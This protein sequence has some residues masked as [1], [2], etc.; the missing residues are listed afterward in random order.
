[1]GGFIDEIAA[2]LD[3]GITCQAE[4]WA[5][6]GQATRWVHGLVEESW[7]D[8]WSELGAAEALSLVP[9]Q[10]RPDVRL[11]LDEVLGDLHSFTIEMLLAAAG[12][13][14]LDARRRVDAVL[15]PMIWGGKLRALGQAAEHLGLPT[16]VIQDGLLAPYGPSNLP[17]VRADH[18]LV[19]GPSG[20]KWFTE[21]GMDRERLLVAGRCMWGAAFSTACASRA[22]SAS[23]RTPTVLYLAPRPAS[24]GA[25]HSLHEAE[26][27]IEAVCSAVSMIPAC[28]LVV[29]LHPRTKEHP[30][31]AWVRRVRRRLRV[32]LGLKGVHFDSASS[33]E[34]C[35]VSA[36]VVVCYSSTIPIQMA[37]LGKR[38]VIVDLS[39]GD[40]GSWKGWSLA[41]TP[42]A[43]GPAVSDALACRDPSDQQPL[44]AN[45]AE[46]V[47]DGVGLDGVAAYINGI[48]A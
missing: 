31:S 15:L 1:M 3:A 41:T 47:S 6:D 7:S 33:L 21:A 23:G 37:C 30:G 29:R 46:H 20:L 24:F 45:V 19:L 48:V 40:S 39:G 2:R 4:Q 8:R 11:V 27:Q 25:Q 38:V 14:Q 16:F 28:R 43:I 32:D 36:D 18:A 42:G 44:V 22:S 12:L 5:S 9:D 34:E 26:T 35:A 10:M 17:P 13:G